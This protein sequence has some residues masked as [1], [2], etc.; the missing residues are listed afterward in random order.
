MARNNFSPVNVARTRKTLGRPGIDHRRSQDFYWGANQKSH[1]MTSSESEIF[2]TGTFCGTKFCSMEDQKP[3]PGL[4]RAK[5][6]QRKESLNP[7]VEKWKYLNWETCVSKVVQLKKKKRI[8]DG[9]WKRSH[10]P[11]EAMGVG[12]GG[13]GGGEVFSGWASF[14]NFRGKNSHFNAIGSHFSRVQSHLK[15]LDF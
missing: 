14:W 1:A 2:K 12:G 9:S 4:V 11:P 5:Y 8:T 3:W 15:E 6:L 10:Q 13:G 7:E